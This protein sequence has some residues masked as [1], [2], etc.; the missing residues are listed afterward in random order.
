MIYGARILIGNQKIG[1]PDRAPF[2]EKSTAAFQRLGFAYEILRS[3]SSRRTY[4]R[5][6]RGGRRGDGTAFAAGEQTFR[7]AVA[8]LLYEFMNGDFA[9]VKTLL[10]ALNK[11]YPNLITEEAIT[12]IE[13]SWTRVRELILTTR[14]YALLIS[15]E[16]GRIYRVQKKLRSLGYLDVIGRMRMSAQL[17]KVTLAVPMRVDRALRQKAHRERRAKQAGWDAVGLEPGSDKEG[18]IL[19]EKVFK[20][21]EF[22]V[23][24][25]ADDEEAD[26]AWYTSTSRAA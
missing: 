9:L 13:H 8:S 18:G 21:L 24:S 4:D 17:V 19:N 6:S 11:R 23:G 16:L 3:P 22:I 7:G 1:H 26:A 14:S 10:Q 15:I 2:H 20:V 12:G 5:A 25:S